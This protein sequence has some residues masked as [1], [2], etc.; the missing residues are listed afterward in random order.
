MDYDELIE[1]WINGNRRFVASHVAKMQRHEVLA[2]AWEFMRKVDDPQA[3]YGT[4]ER[5]TQ[6]EER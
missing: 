1:S 3:E 5:L 6:T 4:L 2:F